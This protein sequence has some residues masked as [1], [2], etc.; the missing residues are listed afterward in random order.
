[1]NIIICGAFT[2]RQ[3]KPCKMCR[4]F[5]GWGISTGYCSVKNNDVTYGSH[6]KYYKRASYMYFKDGR[7]K[8]PEEEFA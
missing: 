6:C 1:M 3:K 2:G 5:C 4:S 8:H 7:C